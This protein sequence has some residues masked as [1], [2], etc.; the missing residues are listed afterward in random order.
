[1]C[2]SYEAHVKL[3]DLGNQTKEHSSTEILDISAVIKAAQRKDLKIS[4]K[5]AKAGEEGCQT[6]PRWWQISSGRGQRGTPEAL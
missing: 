2:H 3:F 4:E 5:E 1:M 6:A